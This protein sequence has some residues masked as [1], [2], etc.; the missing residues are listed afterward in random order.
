[1]YPEI[2]AFQSLRL[3]NNYRQLILFLL[4]ALARKEATNCVLYGFV[5]IMTN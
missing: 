2:I 5:H 1:M 3:Q 4:C